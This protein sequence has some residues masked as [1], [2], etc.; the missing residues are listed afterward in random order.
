VPETNTR[1]WKQFTSTE[2]GFTVRMPAKPEE[3]KRAL[4]PPNENVIM[5]SFVATTVA[6]Y[7]VLYA[8]YPWQ[9]EGTERA[10]S[11]LTS[12]RDGGV[13]GIS[14]G[15]LLED[16]ERPFDGHPGR[17]Y[18]AEF[19][20]G[21][22]IRCVMFVVKNRLYMVTASTYGSNAPSPSIAR[23]Y[24]NAAK[25]FLDTFKLTSGEPLQADSDVLNTGNAGEVDR[26][27]EDKSINVV[28]AGQDAETK[29]QPSAQRHIITGGVLNGKA[30]Y[31]PHPQYPPI[32]K[33]ARAQGTVT[34]KIIVNEEGTVM[35]AQAESGHPLLQAAAVKAA[36][37]ARFAP[38][39][40]DGKPVKVL[41]VITYNFVLQ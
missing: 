6:E 37:E 7:G 35:A 39:L 33:A 18:R 15:R 1:A 4:A 38:T 30:S 32:A 11:F 40:L 20:G 5:H 23:M 22:N 27:L 10:N 14:G 31:K 25:T 24:E 16:E 19:G 28:S 2:G 12:V 13:K 8:D 26:L 34:V 3:T 29:P 9:I 17:V 41:G 21:Y 36:R